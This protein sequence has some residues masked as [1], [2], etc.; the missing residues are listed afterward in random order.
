M[1]LL[2]QYIL[3]RIVQWFVVIFVGI[4]ITFLIPRLSPVN[5]VDNALG[6][7][8]SFQTMDPEASQQMRAT[9]LDLYGLDGSI[10]DQ[11]LNF[12]GRLIKGDLG[13]SFQSF[14]TPV[15]Q[16][17]GAGIGWTIG[18][19]GTSILISWT[20][21]L[22]LGSL[23][24]YFSNTWWAKL[25]E[26]VVITIYPVPYYILAF[27]LLMLF[28]YYWPLFPLVGGSRGEPAFT[29]EF[30]SSVLYFGFL[31]A[32]SL[33]IGGTAFRFIMAKALASTEMTSDYVQYAD[34]A[35]V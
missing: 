12:W 23:A 10:V 22:I 20:L 31:P 19:L 1:T 3:P 14:P 25:L 32:L 7:L 2:R 34:L 9:L 28:T 4:S 21:G 13:P 18:L 33:V 15:M 11:Y 27:I 24:G 17:I 30:I 6:R 8:T 26:R 16:I 29:W 5:P 35:A